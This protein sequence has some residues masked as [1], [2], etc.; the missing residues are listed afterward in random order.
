MALLLKA[1][2]DPA[3]L[4]ILSWGEPYEFDFFAAMGISA[5]QVR[6]IACTF[7]TAHDTSS[8]ANLSNAQQTRKN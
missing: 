7:Y 4:R 1:V 3:L 5:T 2:E 6:L 8:P